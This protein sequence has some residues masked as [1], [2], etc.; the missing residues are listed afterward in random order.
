MK[1]LILF[2]T[3]T[4]YVA[5]DATIFVYH[6]FGDSRFPSTNTPLEELTKEFDYFKENDYEV[7]PL[8]KLINTLKNDKIVNDKW[9]VLTIDDSYKSFYQNGLEIFKQYNY[10]FTLFVQSETALWKTSKEYMNKDEILEAAKYGEIGCHS[11]KHDYLPTKDIEYIKKDTQKCIDIMS[12]ILQEKPKYYAYP[13]GSYNM[14]VKK[15]VKSLGFEA[16]LNQ[17][18]G[19]V[20]T[21]SDRF[22]LFRVALV[23]EIDNFKTKFNWKFLKA[24]WEPLYY[25]KD[26]ILKEININFEDDVKQIQIFVSGHGWSD[27]IKVKNGKLHKAVNYKLDKDIVRVFVKDT[28]NRFSSMILTKGD[29]HAK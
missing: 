5:A 16:I 28:K 13:Y 8:K 29:I 2:L 23:G 10:P 26:G 27:W 1:K 9:V 22:N 25:P 14:E 12:E 20:T 18:N 3:L 15:A 17:S 24:S 21:Q 7:I 4:L 6:R 11:H 19:S